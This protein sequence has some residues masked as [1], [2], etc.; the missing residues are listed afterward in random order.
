MKLFPI[1][2]VL[3]LA[4]S[5]ANAERGPVEEPWVEPS[6][7]LEEL[8]FDVSTESLLEIIESTETTQAQ[9]LAIRIVGLRGEQ[10]SAPILR[11]LMVA[12]PGEAIRHRSAVALARLG[13]EA[14]LAELRRLC[15][16]DHHRRFSFAME[17][18]SLGDPTCLSMVLEAAGSTDTLVQR[19]AIGAVSEFYPLVSDVDR[20]R[21]RGFLEQM[22]DH[23]SRSLRWIAL[24]EARTTFSRWR[25]DLEEFQSMLSRYS[26]KEQDPELKAMALRAL[27]SWKDFE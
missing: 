23:E 2:I 3:A 24:G 18:A 8:G 14:G 12:A 16:T 6:R 22:L 1:L 21:L 5:W 26:D 19:R 25:L 9:E 10:E 17:L 11:R 27:E 7:E 4:A 15:Y 13:D 20:R